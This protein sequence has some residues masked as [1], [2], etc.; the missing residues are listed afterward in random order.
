MNVGVE[1]REL[2]QSGCERA[3]FC[4]EWPGIYCE[5]TISNCVA[6]RNNESLISPVPLLCRV[7][8]TVL[9]CG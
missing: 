8:R 4:V 1:R 2:R 5:F 3:E 7:T 6:D 9:A